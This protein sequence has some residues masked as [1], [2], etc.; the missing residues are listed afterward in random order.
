MN[1]ID[2]DTHMYGVLTE[3]IRVLFP[4]TTA[5]QDYIKQH[6]WRDREYVGESGG[7]VLGKG[8]ALT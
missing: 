5:P 4:L 6:V 7:R 8:L 2:I 1:T 3:T